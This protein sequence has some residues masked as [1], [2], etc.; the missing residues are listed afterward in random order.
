MWD[1]HSR[2]SHDLNSA[3][4]ASDLRLGRSLIGAWNGCNDLAGVPL[5][6]DS[7]LLVDTSHA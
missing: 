6:L 5:K 1:Q 4:G 2:D 3:K 7:V